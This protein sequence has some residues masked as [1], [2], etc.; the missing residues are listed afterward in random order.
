ME[1]SWWRVAFG[2]GGVGV[3][4][5]IG[6]GE[7]EEEEGECERREVYCNRSRLCLFIY[8]DEIGTFFFFL[9]SLEWIE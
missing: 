1:C 4:R 8:V 6:I 3:I 5:W 9:L 2:F 7:D